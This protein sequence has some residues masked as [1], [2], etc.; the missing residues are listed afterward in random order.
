MLDYRP[1]Y[2][3]FPTSMQLLLF[4]LCLALGISFLCSVLE[5]V[6]LSTPLSFIS[7]K[8]A[9]GHKSAILLKSLKTGIDRPISAILSLNTIAHTVGAAGVG[10]QATNV[11]GD[12]YFGLISAILTLLIL[13][14]SEI[15][16]KTIGASYYRSLAIPSAPVILALIYICYPLVWMSDFLTKIIA[17]KNA[18]ASFSREEVSAMVDAGTKEGV[19][20]NQEN[21]IFQ[22]IIKM[23]KFS[24]REVMT[25]RV[26][27][28]I[29]DED[30]TLDDFYE[31]EKRRPY[32]RIPIYQEDKDNITGYVLFMDI[33]ENLNEDKQLMKL[34]EIKRPILAI[35]D[36]E[37]VSTAWETL[38]KQ[39]EHIA[40]IVDE[41]GT[42]EGI[43]T[44]EDI[45]ET[46]F[47]LE[48]MDEKDTVVDMQ[49]FARDKWIARKLNFKQYIDTPNRLPSS[50]TLG[51]A[52]SH[53]S[54][55]EPNDEVNEINKEQA[56]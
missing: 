14:L 34:H 10:A 53:F 7:M 42:F 12:G 47:G 2:D 49:K 8:E 54:L 29:A 51:N 1:K 39:R 6:L 37:T 55:V 3:I 38:I 45:M 40:M 4:Y 31:D 25:P 18:D 56:S 50:T 41:Y 43:I 19:I 35:S 48:I 11:F 5:A 26:V 32:S 52:S 15:I 30:E 23:E 24:V 21:I 20:H 22:N 13:V 46:I 36:K 16:P 44:M 17:N 28:T 27:C 9:E 33:M